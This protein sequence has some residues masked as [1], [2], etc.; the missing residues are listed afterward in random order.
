[1]LADLCLHFPEVR[2]AFDRVDRIY[3]DHPRGYV[4]SDWIFPRPAFSDEERRVAEER[5]MQMDIAVEAV[6][7]ANQA[8][9]QRP[10]AARP[11]RRTRASATAPASTR[12]LRAAGVLVVDTEERLPSFS[13]RLHRD[14]DAGLRAQADLPQATAP[15][16]SAGD[17]RAE[18][19]ALARE[20]GGEL[21]VAMDNCPHQVVL[22][23][24]SR[25]DR[26]GA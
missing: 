20:A 17:A 16:R 9:A 5:L 6:L 13:P 10:A 21:F 26:A 4:T 23:G 14:Y 7:T 15:R 1:M 25:G 24:Q 8:S 18:V 22:V 2:E 19:E 3:G 11:P 12:P